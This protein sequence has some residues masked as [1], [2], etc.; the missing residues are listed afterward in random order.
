MFSDLHIS[1]FHSDK[2]T[3]VDAKITV[4]ILGSLT[5]V[6]TKVNSGGE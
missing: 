1:M 3:V 2:E 4:R 6:V 5:N